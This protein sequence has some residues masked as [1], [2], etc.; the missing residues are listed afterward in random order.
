MFK[1]SITTLLSISFIITVSC[2]N[3]RGVERRIYLQS[4]ATNVRVLETF[5]QNCEPLETIIG[6][7]AAHASGKT[8]WTFAMNDLRNKAAQ[9]GVSTVVLER[10]KHSNN[11]NILKI[12]VFGKLMRCNGNSATRKTRQPPRYKAI[13]PSPPP[14]P[15]GV[16]GDPG[17]ITKEND[18]PDSPPPA[19]TF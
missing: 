11:G 16:V 7:G 1:L 14:S 6:V 2:S 10:Y 3:S 5:P 17:A 4:P 18:Y 13:R 8:V 12:Q 9:R 15:R 19:T